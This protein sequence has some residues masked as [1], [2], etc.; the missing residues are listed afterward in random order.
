MKF[1]FIPVLLAVSN[2][3]LA[4]SITISGGGCGSSGNFFN[5]GPTAA[6]SIN[7]TQGQAS[8]AC[9]SGV[10]GSTFDSAI[11]GAGFLGGLVDISHNSTGTASGA[12]V[13]ARFQDDVIFRSL[14]VSSF[15]TS[16]GLQLTGTS[17]FGADN[18]DGFSIG[19]SVAMPGVF[20]QFGEIL[21][22]RFSGVQRFGTLSL[23]SPDG[24]PGSVTT[25]LVT[26]ATNSPIPLVLTLELGA[27]SGAFGHMT[28]DY[29]HT[30]SFPTA[31]P[32]F[33]NLPA[34]VTV[35]IPGLNVFNNQWTDPRATNAV[36]EPETYAM[37]LAGLGLLGFVARRGK[38][39]AA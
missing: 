18:G 14:T 29:S 30:L 7:I 31:G 20:S 25:Q 38:Q 3:A 9:P 39:K 21:F 28:L 32:V 13:T 26:V 17:N 23:P 11:A 33:S 19:L 34:G 22:D 12:G 35:D 27:F 2:A 36:P 4:G 1:A 6:N 10:G 16:L 5:F 8:G 15:T 37:L 24:V